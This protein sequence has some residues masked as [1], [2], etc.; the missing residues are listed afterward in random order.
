MYIYIYIYAYMHI[1]IYMSSEGRTLKA[2]QAC[3]QLKMQ[4]C[5]S[6]M[7]RQVSCISLFVFKMQVFAG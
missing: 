7:V 1:Y 3:W 2:G 5:A 4:V 6:F